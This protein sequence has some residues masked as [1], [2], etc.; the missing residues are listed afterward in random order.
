MNLDSMRESVAAARRENK[1]FWEL[2]LETDME[3]RTVSRT[4]SLDKM[5]E[6]WHAMREASEVY[7]GD[8]RSVSGLVGGDGKRM[9]DYAAAQSPI[10]GDFTAQ[11]IAEALSMGESNACMR[12]IVAAPTAG[13]CGVLP[14]VLIPLYWQDNV[15]EERM[16]EALFT[17]SGIGAVIAY[18]ACISGAAGGCQAEIGSAS[19]MAAGALVYLRRGT[20]EQMCH[21]VAMALKNLLGLVCDPVAGLVEVPCVKRNVIGAVNAIAAADMALAGIVSRIPVDE[22]IDAMGEVG[23]RLP[24]EFRETALGGLAATPTGR[25]VKQ[26][27]AGEEKKRRTLTI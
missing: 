17:A 26:S 6:A 19:A 22:V 8:R 12:R 16:L 9:R 13:A 23:R 3:N 5:S 18:R 20:D 7:T 2:V 25:A 14:A 11:V 27:L 15:P 24:V 1:R 21:A 4:A 10:G